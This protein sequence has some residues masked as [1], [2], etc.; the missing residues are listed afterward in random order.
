MQERLM[1]E[2]VEV[3]PRLHRGVVHLTVGHTA[4]GTW[5]PAAPGE[6]DLDV[7]AAGR[8]VERAGLDQPRR[9]EAEAKLEEI[10][11]THGT[12]SCTRGA[13]IVASCSGPSR[14]GLEAP[15]QPQRQRAGQC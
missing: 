1:L 4:G 5:E 9:H 11:I 13:W 10:G 14:H 3:A 12:G 7:E 8:G 6:V 15:S 2:K